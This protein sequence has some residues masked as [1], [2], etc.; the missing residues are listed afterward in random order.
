MIEKAVEFALVVSPIWKPILEVFYDMTISHRVN[1]VSLINPENIELIQFSD[2]I[3][4]I[5]EIFRVDH[6]NWKTNKSLYSY[7]DHSSS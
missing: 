2:D 7:N 3:E 4:E 6:Q 1:N 5:V